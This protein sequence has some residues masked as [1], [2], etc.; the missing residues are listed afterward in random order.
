MTKLSDYVM[1][2]IADTGVKHVFMLPGGGAMHLND[3]LGRCERLEYICNLHEQACAV[4]GDAYAQY[5][6]NLGVCLVTTGPGSTNALT[7]VAAGWVDSTPMLVISGQVKR[8]DS[9]VGKGIRQMGFQEINIVPVVQ[10]ITKY[11]VTVTEP[12]KIRYHMEKAFW[13][14]R[15]GRPGPC[16]VDI[17]LDVQAAQIEPESLEAFDPEKEGLIQKYDH[18]WLSS[19][20]QETLELLKNSSRPVILVGNG[21]RLAKAE[22]NFLRMAEKLNVPVLTTW[23]AL[24]FLAEEDPLFVGRS[25]LVAQRA[26]NFAQQ[27]S[28]WLLMLGARMDMGQTAYMHK[29]LARGAKKIMVDID[30]NEINKM[31]TTIEIPIPVDAGIFISTMLAQLDNHEIEQNQWVDWWQHCRAWKKNYPVVLPEYW[32][33]DDGISIYALVDAI[34]EAMEPG[35]LVAPGSSG[36]AGEVT[37]QALK[38][39][40]GIRVFNSTALGAMGFGIS[41]AIGGCVASGGKRTICI[42][43]DGSFAMNTQELETIRRLRLPVKFFVLDNDGYASIR[44]TQKTYFEG[45]F[46]GSSKEGGLTLPNL[47]NIANAYGINFIEME[48]SRDIKSVTAKSLETEGAIICRVKVSPRQVTAP[49]VTSRQHE[50][51]NMETAPMEY[52]WP[53]VQENI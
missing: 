51:G 45:R 22:I 42:D 32:E 9:A 34:S 43:G 36:A 2:K 49:R 40:K 35:D 14:A 15:N 33:Y 1:E 21:V 39:K 44:A 41:A 24:D 13:M 26:A 52:M 23:K 8:S 48:S 25:G 4:A 38:A 27:K 31:Q 30:E 16:W 11:A 17:P 37:L 5:T 12:S 20:V 18:R 19:K 50:D 46:Y 53:E 6:N 10:S 7:G 47:E 3:S 29:Y 28:D